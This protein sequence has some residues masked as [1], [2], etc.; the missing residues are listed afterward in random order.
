MGKKDPLAAAI[1]RGQ[2]RGESAAQ[3]AIESGT[4]SWQDFDAPAVPGVSIHPELGVPIRSLPKAVLKLGTAA[5]RAELEALVRVY[6]AEIKAAHAAGK[7]RDFRPRLLT[8]EAFEQ[9]FRGGELDSPS[10]KRE[11]DLARRALR[12]SRRARNGAN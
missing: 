12:F 2:R 10:A 5:E 3:E 11:G 4:G 8:A 7:L 1:L 9:R 6:N